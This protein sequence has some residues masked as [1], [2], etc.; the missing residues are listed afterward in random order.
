MYV[1]DNVCMYIMC[2][3][4]LITKP[5]H[6]SSFLTIMHEAIPSFLPTGFLK[7]FHDFSSAP[8]P[9]KFSQF[10]ICEYPWQ[11]H[12][13]K[14]K[15]TFFYQHGLLYFYFPWPPGGGK[16]KDRL[17]TPNSANVSWGAFML[18]TFYTYKKIS[19]IYKLQNCK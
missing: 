8:W 4:S 16:L 9:D 2:S 5:F 19:W 6:V 1:F 14:K 18:I 12:E 17:S 15:C 10:H 11:F 13:P 3:Y 7:T